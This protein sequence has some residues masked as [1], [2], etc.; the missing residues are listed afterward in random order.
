[1]SGYIEAFEKELADGEHQ[2]K[3]SKFD[4][5]SKQSIVTSLV[6][7]IEHESNENAGQWTMYICTKFSSFDIANSDYKGKNLL[8]YIISLIN[9][10]RNI[11]N[12]LRTTLD[13]LLNCGAKANKKGSDGMTAIDETE[14]FAS[15]A[16]HS[17]DYNSLV[18]L[19]KYYGYKIVKH[20]TPENFEFEG[21]MIVNGG[22]DTD[23]MKSALVKLKKMVI[24]LKKNGFG[25]LCYGKVFLIPDKMEGS[26]F[27]KAQAKY[28]SIKAAGKYYSNGDFIVINVDA[29]LSDRDN[30]ILIHELGHREWF[31]FLSP[32]QRQMWIGNYEDRGLVIR[33]SHVNFIFKAVNDSCESKVDALKF[34]F[35]DYSTFDYVKFLRIISAKQ[36]QFFLRDIL[37]NIIMKRTEVRSWKKYAPN[38]KTRR[39]QY[40]VDDIVEQGVAGGLFSDSRH[41]Y[42]LAEYFAG[43]KK[44]EDLIYGLQRLNEEQMRKEYEWCKNALKDAENLSSGTMKSIMSDVVGTFAILPSSVSDYGKNNDQEDYAETFMYFNLG[45]RKKLSPDVLRLFVN[46]HDIHLASKLIK[47]ARNM[48]AARG[49]QVRRK[50][51]DLMRDVGRS[52]REKRETDSKP[53]REDLRRIYREKTKKEKDVETDKDIDLEQDDT[54][55]DDMKL[56]RL[57]RISRRL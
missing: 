25:N 57:L 42:A 31:K 38:A 53:P 15:S 13:I 8:A 27:N 7:I 17:R 39:K 35:I 24:D 23:D 47:I 48:L 37:D 49:L 22:V 32:T 6:D 33:K 9:K 36:K 5:S 50:D 51:K 4:D 18:K 21:F 16:I 43:K 10:G 41:V 56:A 14:S 26:V 28:L 34:K 44:R 40:V 54:T 3:H 29:F 11:E 20:I 55:K 52:V 46:I 12:D 2:L 1:M 30:S 45:Y 19:L